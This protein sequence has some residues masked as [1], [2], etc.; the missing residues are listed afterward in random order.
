MVVVGVD[1]FSH[2]AAKLANITVKSIGINHP[3]NNVYIVLLANVQRRGA[4]YILRWE[5]LKG[6]K[7]KLCP[8]SQP[9]LLCPPPFVCPV[10]IGRTFGYYYLVGSLY[11][12]AALSKR[13]VWHYVVGEYGAI[14]VDQHYLMPCHQTPILETVVEQ[15]HIGLRRLC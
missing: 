10:Q 9:Q 5:K 2:R 12:S 15:Y 4:K 11:A 8:L 7:P 6:R 1:G 3:C 13:S 14:E